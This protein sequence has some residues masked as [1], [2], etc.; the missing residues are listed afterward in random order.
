[1]S[2][3]ICCLSHKLFRELLPFVKLY[4]GNIVPRN[5]LILGI[6]SPFVIVLTLW[7]LLLGP[8]AVPTDTTLSNRW[9]LR[10]NGGGSFWE[11]GDDFRV[12]V[13][14]FHTY[15]TDILG[16]LEKFGWWFEQD[17][18]GESEDNSEKSLWVGEGASFGCSP[19]VRF[20]HSPRGNNLGCVSVLCFAHRKG[21]VG[22]IWAAI[23]RLFVVNK[24]QE[25]LVFIYD[26]LGA[27]GLISASAGAPGR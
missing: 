13:L 15:L 9:T 2:T 21:A 24:P 12:D 19:G 22:L 7:S 16:F 6:L 8:G 25:A 23:G 11:E 10:G 18:G 4:S 5:V 17:I 1:M 27:F 20:D 26:Q 3:I 14:R